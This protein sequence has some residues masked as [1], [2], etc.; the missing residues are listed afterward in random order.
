MQGYSQVPQ[1]LLYS[2][3]VL[4]EEESQWPEVKVRIDHDYLV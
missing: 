4:K 3:R 2:A 1:T